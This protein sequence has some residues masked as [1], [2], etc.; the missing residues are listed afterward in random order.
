MQREHDTYDDGGDDGGGEARVSL[1]GAGGTSS[2]GEGRAGKGA[3]KGGGASEGGG[4]GGSKVRQR[5]RRRRRRR[6]WTRPSSMTWC[7][8]C[9]RAR[10]RR[11]PSSCSTRHTALPGVSRVHIERTRCESCGWVK[12]SI[13]T[14]YTSGRIED[15]RC[16]SSEA[17]ASSTAHEQSCSAR[18]WCMLTQS[19]PSAV[20]TMYRATLCSAHLQP[21]PAISSTGSVLL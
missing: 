12:F 13:Y 9:T 5:R 18:H 20:A 2:G 14:P 11:V 17:T 19:L 10:V 3:S 6:V 7:R 16:D 1:R 8:A 15:A 21:S 4:G